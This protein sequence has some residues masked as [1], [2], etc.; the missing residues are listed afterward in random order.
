MKVYSLE[1]V[2]ALFIHLN[3][4]VNE[5]FSFLRKQPCSFS[6]VL[7]V[8]E[9]ILSGTQVYLHNTTCILFQKYV[10]IQK[11]KVVHI[12][13]NVILFFRIGMQL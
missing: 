2:L 6:R 10:L 9:L 7:I 11:Y 5:K 8:I 3:I 13:K 4:D 1:A 12:F